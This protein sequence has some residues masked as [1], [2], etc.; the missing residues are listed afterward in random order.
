MECDSGRRACF[1]HWIMSVFREILFFIL[2]DYSELSK[3]DDVHI[4]T[5]LFKCFL[6]ELEEP[7]VPD[8]IKQTFVFDAKKQEIRTQN[9]DRIKKQLDKMSKPQRDTLFYIL[10]HLKR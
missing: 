10:N 3:T 1:K 9:C 7:A 8:S 6:R 5:G 2:G 4:L